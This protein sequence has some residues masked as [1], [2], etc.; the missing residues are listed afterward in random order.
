LQAESLLQKAW[1]FPQLPLV[2]G[3][4]RPNPAEQAS[5]APLKAQVAQLST[6]HP[7]LQTFVVLLNK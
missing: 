5:Q 1:H 7:L 2:P 4:V 3:V 6:P